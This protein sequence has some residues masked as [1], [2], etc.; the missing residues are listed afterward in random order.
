MTTA[1][2]GRCEAPTAQ[3]RA[4]VAEVTRVG[5]PPGRGER[6]PPVRQRWGR[7]VRRGLPAPEPAESGAHWAHGQPRHRRFGPCQALP[8]GAR[9]RWGAMGAVGR[10]GGS[11]APLARLRTPG[12]DGCPS[13]CG[14]S[15]HPTQPHAVFGKHARVF[16]CLERLPTVPCM[17]PRRPPPQMDAAIAIA[18]RAATPRGV[19]PRTTPQRPPGPRPSWTW[20]GLPRAVRPGRHVRSL[21]AQPSHR[22]PPACRAWGHASL[23]LLGRGRSVPPRQLLGHLVGHGVQPCAPKRH[24]GQRTPKRLGRVVRDCGAQLRRSRVPLERVAPRHDSQRCIAGRAAHAPGPTRAR[25]ALKLDWPPQSCDRAAATCSGSQPP[26]A[27]R[28]GPRG[29]GVCTAGDGRHDWLGETPGALRA[30]VPHRGGHSRAGRRRLVPPLRKALK[31]GG[32]ALGELLASGAPG[33]S[34][35]DLLARN[36]LSSSQGGLLVWQDAVTRSCGL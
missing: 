10:P 12:V 9:V 28:T 7:V 18:E 32:K 21:Q 22:T 19:A 5:A 24:A 30:H 25:G 1:L 36:N 26:R 13:L 23:A 16:P 31:P 29:A 35:P 6:G 15:G 2:V 17:V 11:I 14:P 8:R 33:C 3:R 4:P 20:T 27:P 34:C